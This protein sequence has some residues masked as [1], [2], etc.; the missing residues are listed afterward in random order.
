[1]TTERRV[2]SRGVSLLVR[3]HGDPS[4][5][6]VVLVHG[7][8]DTSR[9]WDELVDRL[10]GRY[11]VV[12]YDV[13]GAGGSTAPRGPGGYALERLAEDLAAVIDAVSPG[14]A[15]HVLGHDWGS[16]QSWEAVTT[17]AIASK[18]ASY[19]TISGPSLDHVRP[20]IEKRLRSGRFGDLIA[21]GPRSWYVYFFHG[22]FVGFVV[23]RVLPRRFPEFLRRV[24]GLE[25]REGH[26]AATLGADAAR[27]VA[28]YRANILPRMQRPRSGRTDVPVQLVVASRDAALSPRLFADVE[29]FAPNLWRRRI[30]A[31]H[32]VIR[33]QPDL[34]GRMISEFVDHIEGAPA[35]R[36]LSRARSGRDRKPFQDHL[37]VVTGAGSGIGRATALAFAERGA[38]VVAADIDGGAADRTAGLA[39]LIG[40]EAHAFEV[41][42]S[43]RDAMERFAKTVLHDFGVPDVVVNNAGIGLAGSFM[44]TEFDDWRRV[45]DVNLWGV[46]HGSLLF[47]REMVER[48]EGG[49]IVNVASAA[50]FLPSRTL[51]AYSTSK[52]AVL[53]LSEC[54]RAELAGKG[55]GVSAICPGLINTSITRTSRFVGLDESEQVRRRRE[56]V[57]IYGL[58]NYSPDRVA[59]AIV[60]AVRENRAVVPVAPEAHALRTIARVSPG[61]ART[62]GRIDARP[63]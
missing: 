19:T 35:S 57:R 27:G 43:D 17:P 40:P 54:L 52:A 38:Q 30:P 3:E 10:Q 55:I 51:P 42:V 14:R 7:W 5:P 23:K 32:W 48:A 29:R 58:R 26:P 11:H 49:H 21:Q 36:A 45:L 31:S 8:P 63:R 37:V 53:M 47:G 56:A 34:I 33:S 16:I 25:P 59:L 13:R 9:V 2:S 39:R 12:T 6:T 22:P 41:D 46:I 1:V 61:L 24:E 50:A 4:A 18:I 60:R 15:A 62:L 28:M 20:W 44:D